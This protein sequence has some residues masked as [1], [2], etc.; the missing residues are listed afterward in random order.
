MRKEMHAQTM[1]LKVNAEMV[2]SPN[3][4]GKSLRTKSFFLK[5]RLKKKKNKIQLKT[6]FP[7][8]HAA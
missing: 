1:E 8:P 3:P 7:L 6:K 2:F 4:N 5:T